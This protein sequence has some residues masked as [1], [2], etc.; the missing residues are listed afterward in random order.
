MNSRQTFLIASALSLRKSEIVLK[1]GREFSHQPDQFE[2]AVSFPL[3]ATA[4]AST[5]DVA[6][7]IE[8]QQVGR[9]VSR[10]ASVSRCSARKAKPVKIKAVNESLDE[11]NRVIIRDV[12][13]NGLREEQNIRARSAFNEAQWVLSWNRCVIICYYVG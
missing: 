7:D 12:I 2:V 4:G 11:A 13:I 8:L 6:V 5:V 3:K 10:T 9:R 1:S